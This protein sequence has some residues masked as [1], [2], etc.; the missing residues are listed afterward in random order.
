MQISQVAAILSFSAAASA[1][2]TFNLTQAYK[3]GNWEKYHCL[4]NEK[5][6]SW[7]PKCLHTCQDSA[8][9]ADGC[10]PDDFACHCINYSV[11]TNTL[12]NAFKLIEPCAFPPA[13]GGKGTCTS[14]EL[15]A[16]RPVV[17]DM[18]NFFNATLYANYRECEQDLSEQVTYDI[19]RKENTIAIDHAKADN[20]KAD[21]A[22]AG[23]GKA[24]NGKFDDMMDD[25][26]GDFFGED[27]LNF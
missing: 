10:A 21:D 22:K 7:L 17:Q 4:N 12:S 16:A 8:N 3:E 11:Y 1:A 6:K 9:M 23:N 13:K 27:S 18:C 5:A 24:G 25:I 20:A 2:V 26:F 19:I 14:D 15:K